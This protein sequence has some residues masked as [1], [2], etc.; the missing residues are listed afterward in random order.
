MNALAKLDNAAHMLAEAKSLDEIKHIVDIA[1]A[2]RTYARA[3]KLG[4]E[5]QNHAAELKLRAERKA[6]EMLV[7]LERNTVPGP[8]RGKTISTGGNGF[9]EY[10]EVI[11]Q[12]GSN[13]Q[14]ANRWQAIAAVPEPIFERHI[15]NIK[16]EAQELTTAS[17]LRV[18]QQIRREQYHESMREAP[19]MPDDKFRVWYADPPWQYND[20]GVITDSDN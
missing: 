17:V 10:R 18:A 12:S 8:G 9:S 14:Q 7:L 20:S 5:A 15:A 13:Y 16:A 4:L 11:D 6:G 1:E 3:A 19:P 2:A